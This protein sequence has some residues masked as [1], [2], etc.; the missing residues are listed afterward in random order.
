MNISK[1]LRLSHGQWRSQRTGHAWDRC[2][3]S[4]LD[5]L[6]D[7]APL[8]LDDEAVAHACRQCDLDPDTATFPFQVAWTS[9]DRA[10]TSADDLSIFVPIPNPDNANYGRIIQSHRNSSAPIAIGKYHFNLD[11]TLVLTTEHPTTIV[12]EK[13]WFATPNLRLQVFVSK[14]KLASDRTTTT[15]ISENR[16]IATT[17]RPVA[18]AIA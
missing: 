15:F 12:E 18:G 9:I 3:T 2:E 5:M 11:G 4:E 17:T 1:F 14:P 16:V 13:I 10:S 8:A 7:I 6:L